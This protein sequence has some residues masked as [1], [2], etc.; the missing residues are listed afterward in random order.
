MKYYTIDK[1]IKWLG[2]E[3]E[4][5]MKNL[6]NLPHYRIK[7]Q[8]RFSTRHLRI[9]RER[10]LTKEEGLDEESGSTATY[11]SRKSRYLIGDGT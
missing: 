10:F 4:W 1:A 6:V 9:I 5:M 11:G 8:V 3:P 7:K 2:V